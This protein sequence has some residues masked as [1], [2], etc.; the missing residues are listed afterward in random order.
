MSDN[1]LVAKSR[2]LEPLSCNEDVGYQGHVLQRMRDPSLK[3]FCDVTVIVEGHIF[4]AHRAVLCGASEM[5]RSL[6]AHSRRES[7]LKDIEIKNVSALAFGYIVNYIYN[8]SLEVSTA[9]LCKLLE[10]DTAARYLLMPVS[11]LS[12]LR[13][14]ILRSITTSNV[15]HVGEH[16]YRMGDE[17]LQSEC[18]QFACEHFQDILDG[19]GFLNLPYACME[20]FLSSND[21]VLRE[22]EV[23]LL[24]GMSSWVAHE[25]TSRARCFHKLLEHIRFSDMALEELAAVVEAAGPD[26]EISSRASFAIAHLELDNISMIDSDQGE[27]ELLNEHVGNTVTQ[28]APILRRRQSRGN[29]RGNSIGGEIGCPKFRAQRRCVRNIR[30][31]FVVRSIGNAGQRMQALNSPWYKCGGGLLWRLEV[32]P[33]GSTPALGDYMSVFLRCCN[34]SGEE[35]FKCSTSFSLFLIEQNFGGQEKVFEATKMFTSD[36]PC[37][38]RSRYVSRAELLAEN[39]RA[40]CDPHGNVVVGVSVTY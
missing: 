15:F 27:A 28:A 3:E 40:Y 6:L 35:E 4:P 25:L 10:I 34:G 12:R 16:A 24:H 8:G 33:R 9:H 31:D 20:H 22:G 13:C 26:S 18:E 5:L 1:L 23:P 14:M 30:F 37:W 21:I 38:G 39:G 32:Y 17:D 19:T 2:F 29:Q 36:E 11:M 7:G